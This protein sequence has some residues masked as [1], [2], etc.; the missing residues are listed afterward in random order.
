MRVQTLLKKGSSCS[1]GL[2]V[3][4]MV[5]PRKTSE[6]DLVGPIK[7]FLSVFLEPNE[8]QPSHLEAFNIFSPSVTAEEESFART[9][10][11][12][13]ELQVM[14]SRLFTDMTCQCCM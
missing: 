8:S 3:V 14:G 2:P 12:D 1:G 13:L 7:V 5:G 6:A 9:F 10:G 4:K 11:K